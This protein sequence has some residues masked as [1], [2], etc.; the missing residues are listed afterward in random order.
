MAV[1]WNIRIYPARNFTEDVMFVIERV[2]WDGR[3]VA[4]TTDTIHVHVQ[5]VECPPGEI[6]ALGWLLEASKGLTQTIAA[7]IIKNTEDSVSKADAQ[8]V[9]ATKTLSQDM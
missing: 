6:A 5:M 8:I 9:R 1:G 7:E 4:S 2:D 3:V